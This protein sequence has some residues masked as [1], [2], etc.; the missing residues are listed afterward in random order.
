MTWESCV[1]EQRA[2]QC[3]GW[4]MSQRTG[5]RGSQGELFL[6]VYLE[7][8]QMQT[9]RWGDGEVQRELM[10]SKDRIKRGERW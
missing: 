1:L 9:N 3:I 4:G 5:R 6:V 7:E 2:G 10:G 8:G